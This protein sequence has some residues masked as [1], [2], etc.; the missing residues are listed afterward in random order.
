MKTIV[1]AGGG[2]S[3]WYV[4]GKLLEMG[5]DVEV[6]F[7]EV[8]QKDEVLVS[9]FL[10]FL[11]VK[12]VPT[13]KRN[14]R[15]LLGELGL[16]LC[17]GQAQHSNGYWNTT[18]LL[19]IALITAAAE[20]LSHR[21]EDGSYEIAHGCVGL[22]NDQR[23][24]TNLF[25]D[26][27]PGCTVRTLLPDW[28]QEAG[29]LS[30]DEMVASLTAWDVQCNPDLSA[31]ALWSTDG[32][33]LGVSHEGTKIESHESDWTQ[34]KFVMSNNP[35]E[36]SEI[37]RITLQ[38]DSGQLTQ[39]DKV[40]GTAFELLSMANARAG[41]RG[42]GR[43]GVMENR[44]KGTKCRGVYEAP[45]ISLIATAWSA[46]QEL[47][48]PTQTAKIFNNLSRQ[49]AADVYTGQWYRPNAAEIRQQIS[50]I[51][52]GITGGVVVA[53][54]GG[55]IVTESTWAENVDAQIEQ[56]FARGGVCWS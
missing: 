51:H 30:R 42:I 27:L 19:R 53:M 4:V 54:R 45:G 39:I 26:L 29:E 46:L 9:S 11:K 8:E 1:L 37:D 50:D 25:C 24:F 35:F 7:A 47:C 49:M 55:H 52:A 43:I 20:D 15:P 12:N 38:F 41:E 3:S 40:G 14:L 22:G 5:R 34:T 21:Y 33:V 16:S 2:L 48:L 36:D 23:R 13:L 31:K 44:I 10:N 32:S 18:G 28:A 56:R 17:Q 6:W